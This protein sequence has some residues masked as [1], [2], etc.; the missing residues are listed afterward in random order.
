MNI[1]DWGDNIVTMPK[2][3]KNARH[4]VTTLLRESVSNGERPSRE[5]I[6]ALKLP[7]EH[8][9]QFD[10]AVDDCLGIRETG[11]RGVAN[12]AA[13][14]ASL[15]LVNALPLRLRDPAYNYRDPLTDVTDPAE[16]AAA[17]P[18]CTNLAPPVSATRNGGAA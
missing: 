10:Q 11:A 8:R 4:P 9:L 16:L 5:D 18:R 15:A 14:E 17:I 7:A 6:D 13:H 12:E 1:S 3:T 2:P